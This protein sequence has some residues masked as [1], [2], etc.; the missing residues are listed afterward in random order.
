MKRRNVALVAVLALA[1]SLVAFGTVAF[2][3]DEART[4]NVI[5]TGKVDIDL[6]EKTTKDGEWVDCP[7]GMTLTGVMPGQTV[8]KQVTVANKESMAKAWVRVKVDLSDKSDVMTLD[9]DEA[10]WLQDGDYYYYKTPLDA[11]EVTEPLFNTVTF[12]G[13]KMTND[14]QG[15]ELKIEVKAEAVQWKN[16]TGTGETPITELTAENLSQ[17][18]GWPETT[19]PTP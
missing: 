15:K 7:N 8:D 12:D 1:L 14:Y 2:L 10:H 6:I 16:N 19:T 18:Q 5:T 9:F 11:A 17:I 4:T 13:P 3:S